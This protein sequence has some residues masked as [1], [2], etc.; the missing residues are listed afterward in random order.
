MQIGD[1]SSAAAYLR[2]LDDDLPEHK[3]RD[4]V[5]T[6]PYTA[7]LDADPEALVKILLGGVHRRIDTKGG[8]VMVQ[9]SS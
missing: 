2:E 5:D 6:T 7:S 8:R 3:I 1:E 9:H 4:M